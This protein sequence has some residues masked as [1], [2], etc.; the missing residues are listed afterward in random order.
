MRVEQLAKD[1]RFDLRKREVG[2]VLDYSG[3]GCSMMEDR[4]VEQTLQIDVTLLCDYDS[5]LRIIRDHLANHGLTDRAT[6]RG[7]KDSNV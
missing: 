5:G 4:V 3:G 6:I 7:E 2:D 1:I